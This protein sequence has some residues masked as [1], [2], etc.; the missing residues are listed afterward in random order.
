MFVSKLKGSCIPHGAAPALS[1]GPPH[2]ASSASVAVGAAH[3]EGG[4]ERRAPEESWC[5]SDAAPIRPVPSRRGLLR[6]SSA[7]GI[8]S[9]RRDVTWSGPLQ[10]SAAPAGP[11]ERDVSRDGLISRR[12]GGGGCTAGLGCGGSS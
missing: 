1:S 6:V 9:R 5:D 12:R 2:E 3:R 10:D 8:T 11:G 7:G 4:E